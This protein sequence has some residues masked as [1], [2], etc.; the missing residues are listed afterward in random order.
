MV[1]AMPS[2]QKPTAETEGA[3][4][5]TAPHLLL[6]EV[7]KPI[8]RARNDLAARILALRPLPE[9]VV[10]LD[11]DAWWLPGAVEALAETLRGLPA[12]VAMLAG[13]FCK[14]MPH[15]PLASFAKSGRASGSFAINQGAVPDGA[16]VR[17][18]GC[19]LHACAL[20]TSALAALGEGPFR[21]GPATGEDLAFCA[22]LRERG[23]EIACAPSITFAHVEV[24]TGV[25]YV[26]FSGPLEIVANRARP[27]PPERFFQRL[28][29]AGFK[30]TIVSTAGGRRTVRV[31]REVVERSYGPAFDLH[32]EAYRKR[33][34]A[35]AR[36]TASA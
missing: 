9:V 1:V 20:R 33:R 15:A 12:Q 24:E 7:G 23:F 32:R 22:R 3:L 8:D 26:P 27:L 5:Y 10:L 16:V 29:A 35:R 14:R 25:T 13:G 6:S 4:R 2:R 34:K 11:D 18:E 21:L 30:A 19:G 31:D 17:I 28:R 36:V